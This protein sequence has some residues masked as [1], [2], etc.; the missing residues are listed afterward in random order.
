MHLLPDIRRVRCCAPLLLIPTLAFA[1]VPA[2]E[3]AARR[4]ALLASIDSGVVIAFGAGAPMVDWPN[5]FQLPRFQYLTGFAE[6]DAVLVMVKRTGAVTQTLFVRDRDAGVQ[7]F[8]GPL[9]GPGG[10][11]GKIGITGREL[12]Q[13]RPAL[14]SLAGAGLPFYVIT[15]ILS[16]AWYVTPDSLTRGTRFLNEIQKS[17]P[18][19]VIH[20]MDSTVSRLRARKSPTE[21]ALLRRAVEISGRG[22]VEAMKATAPGCGENEI[23]ALMEG[24]FRRLGADRPGYGSKVASGPSAMI[25]HYDQDNRVMQDGELLLI[26][27][28]AS[29]NHYTGDVSRTFPVN[30]RFT[31]AQKEIYQ[32]VRDAQEASI[33]QIKPGAS[34]AVV[35]DSARQVMNRGLL[36]LGLIESV[37]A[38][39]DAPAWMPCA[40]QG[41]PQR[42]LYT[43]HGVGGH[44]IGLEVH[45]PAQYDDEPNAFQAGDVFAIEPGLYFNSE[46]LASLPDT[47]RN[48]TML[49]KIGPAVERY[50]GIG[51]KIED[52]YALTDSGLEWLSKGVPR[53]IEEIES[54]MREWS[55]ELP[56]GGSCGKP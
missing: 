36:R 15:D 2:A 22:H 18:G 1:Q 5:F 19:L 39:F 26:D 27:A 13:L 53:E 8:M 48:R 56:G 38:I 42:S 7:R 55:G 34:L 14:D 17:Y 52:N 31:P 21:I 51:I 33:R 41:C 6:P 9:S 16:T 35:T 20:P 50:N 45:D 40:N 44:G 4:T 43:W 10:L 12:E 23:Q 25:L 3:Y 11:E 47:P 24:T 46:S 30:G 49:A 37:T 29:F 28:G 32:L 54:L